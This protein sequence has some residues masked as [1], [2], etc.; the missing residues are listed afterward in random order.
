V[1][2]DRSNEKSVGFD[3]N[4]VGEAVA[5]ISLIIEIIQNNGEIRRRGLGS[6]LRV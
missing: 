1:N 5:G 6:I 4:D 3:G 2:N